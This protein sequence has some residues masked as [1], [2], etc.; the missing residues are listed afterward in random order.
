MSPPHSPSCREHAG[1]KA[2]EE[3]VSAASR[4]LMRQID[5][6]RLAKNAVEAAYTAAEEAAQ[7]VWAEITG[8]SLDEQAEPHD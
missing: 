5:A 4:Q 7:S 1:A 8:P 2:R 6:F 3:R